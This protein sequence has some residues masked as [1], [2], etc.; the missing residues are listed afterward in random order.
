MEE[1]EQARRARLRVR[2]GAAVV[3][4]LVALGCAVLA[5]T[6]SDGSGSVEI[7]RD[8]QGELTD[9]G[10]V[11]SPSIFVHVTGAV[12][13]P[14]LFELADG[15]RVIDAI[16]AAGGFIDTAD[17]EQLNLAR[18]LTDGEQFAVL[19]EGEATEDSAASDS[20]VNLN[21]ADA[22][23]LDTLPRVGPALA[24]RILAWREANGR[25]ATIDDLR[26]VSGFGDKTFEGLRELITV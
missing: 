12:V 25:F 21:T 18:L 26:N 10:A 16:A 8:E 13:R 22:A 3:L 1:F 6:L 17:R 19:V 4:V 20:R 23:A 11:T 7:R 9:D 24:A 14:G 5:S 2:V 15:A